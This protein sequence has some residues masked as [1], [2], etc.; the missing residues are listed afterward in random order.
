MYL[1]RVSLYNLWQAEERL[2]DGMIKVLLLDDEK[3][4]LEYLENTVSWE[5]YGFEIVGTLTDAQAALKV[6]RKTRPELIISDVCMYGMDGLDFAA[7]IREIDQNA[8]I[9]FLTGYKNFE[10]VQKAIRLGIDD[11]ILKSDIDEDMFLTKLL[12]IKEKIEKENQKKQ[13]TE[14]VILKELYFNKQEER[15][16]KEI[17]GEEEYIRLH[18][19]YYYILISH[20]Q[21]PRFLN[22]FFPGIVR[23]NEADETEL[24]RM[25]RKEAAG[26]EI[27][28]V[29]AFSLNES[30]V[31][32]IFDLRGLVSQK[33]IHEKIYRLANAVFVQANRM[34]KAG[35]HVTYYPR[36]CAVCQFGKLCRENKS[37][38]EQRYVK[39][40]PQLSE[41]ELE[42]AFLPEYAGERGATAEEIFHAIRDKTSPK[43]A[44]YLE[45][46]MIAVE[47]EDCITYLW[48]L[49][50]IMTALSLMENFL[51]NSG[52]AREFSLAESVNRY[53]LYRPQDVIAFLEYKFEEIDRLLRE[54]SGSS[55]SK[56]VR[57]ALD[58]IQKHYSQEE[59]SANLVA[60]EVGLSNSW[61]STKFKEEV[62]VGI[63]DYLN[64]VRIFHAKKLFDEKD[65]M[66]Y[67]VSEKVGFSSS[68]Y[69]SKIFKQI[70]GQTPNEYKRAGKEKSAR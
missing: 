49:K 6:F 50:E 23:E 34:D 2:G 15:A 58:Y 61:L 4:A 30:E 22:E 14:S 62:G 42:N 12:R 44:E 60:K 67:E 26:M 66:I 41:F 55:Y 7:A 35:F 19:K 29:A 24:R 32:A 56:S 31:L 9:L 63:N 40:E 11:Y 46:M 47:R 3:L 16:Y 18:K 21:I 37:Q 39:R 17:L 45:S 10:Y 52:S 27:R 43:A 59:L 36:S 64:S 54:I 33:E 68:Q 70:T 38:M 13:Y 51:K 48:Y 65:Y 20:R 57:A 1:V 5:D 28:M 53:E 69:F 8:H 25:L